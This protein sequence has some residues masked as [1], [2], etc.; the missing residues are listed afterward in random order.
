MEI[1]MKT[2][3]NGNLH[4]DQCLF[5]HINTSLE[6]AHRE[7]NEA[8]WNFC[9]SWKQKIKDFCQRNVV[10]GLKTNSF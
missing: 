2:I 6:I 1:K 5:E 7:R 4:S 8:V 3:E 10:L 9:A